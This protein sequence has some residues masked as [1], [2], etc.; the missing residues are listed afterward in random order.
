MGEDSD[1]NRRL[2]LISIDNSIELMMQTYLSLP[3]RV[4][5]VEIT[6]KARE[7]YLRNFPSLL[8]G[9]E[10]EAGDRIIGINLGEIEWYHRLRNNL[11]HE[12]N[13]LTVERLKV[14]AYS[15]LAELLLVS[16]FDEKVEKSASKDA[17]KLGKFLLLWKEIEGLQISQ[18]YGET[19]AR[20]RYKSDDGDAYNE[21]TTLISPEQLKVLEHLRKLRNRLVHGEAIPSKV[22]DDRVLLQLELLISHVKGG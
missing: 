2:A 20:A 19:T 9:I 15:E 3:K 7:D 11:Y 4:S 12:G 17:E 6:R 1:S 14:E 13:G 18:E 22:I 5:G 16:L 10:N 21:F 8:D